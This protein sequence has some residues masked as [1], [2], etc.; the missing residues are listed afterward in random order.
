MSGPGVLPAEPLLARRASRARRWAEL[1]FPPIYLLAVTSALYLFF[2]HWTYD[3][4]FITYRYAR[5]LASGVGFV[6]NPGERALSTTTPLF[7][8]LLAPFSLAGAPLPRLANLLGA[9]SLGLGGLAF[10]DLSRTWKAGGVGWA[11]LLLYPAFPLLVSTLGSETPLYLA[12]C[13]GAFACQARGRASAAGLLAGLAVLARPDGALVALLLAADMLARRR[14]PIPW[15]GLAVF[16]G[17]GLAWLAFA[18]AYFG[19]PLPAT[20]AA[21]QQ[22]GAMAVSQRFAPGFLTI[23]DAYES[24]PYLLQ[25]LLAAAGIFYALRTARAWL[26]LLAWPLLYF[27]AY[28]ALGVSRYHWYYAPL[29]PGYLAAVGLGLGVLG[30][31]A[32]ALAARFSPASGGSSIS[33]HASGVAALLVGALLAAF[34]FGQGRT[35]AQAWQHPDERFAIYRAAGEWLAANTRPEER[36]GALEVGIL[37]YYAGRPMVDFAGLIQPEVAARLGE[38]GSYDEAALWAAGRYRPEY[39]VLRVGALPRLEQ[40]YARSRCRVVQR[41]AGERYG[42]SSDLDVFACGQ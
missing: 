29:V 25:A 18:W 34:A 1:A 2:A 11:G 14:R 10:W 40:E 4:P 16:A 24:W 15:G 6:Y 19:S 3:D 42:Y 36:V 27:A 33:R 39:L 30:R 32:G 22:Q 31:R 5:N 26:A 17:L 9:L 20:L 12:L 38:L 23:L 21:K 28:S 7:T 37:G 13:L 41:F 8:L 35:L